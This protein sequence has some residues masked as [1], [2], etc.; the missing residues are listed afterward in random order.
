M[1]IEFSKYFHDK[2]NN[3]SLVEGYVEDLRNKADSSKKEPFLAKMHSYGLL[4]P[5]Y[6]A[7]KSQLSK[8]SKFQGQVKTRLVEKLQTCLWSFKTNSLK[9]CRL[10]VN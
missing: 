10:K 2:K 3:V 8:V 4:N 9:N 5:F 1:N 6:T 7:I